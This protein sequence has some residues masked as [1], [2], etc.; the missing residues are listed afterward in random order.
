M[1]KTF[2]SLFFLGTCFFAGAQ[3]LKGFHIG[4]SVMP[5]H[6]WYSN[7]FN[8]TTE[9]RLKSNNNFLNGFQGAINFEYFINNHIGL[10]TGLN[11]SLQKQLFLVAQGDYAN[12]NIN[13]NSKNS[14]ISHRTNYLQIP[15]II[16]YANTINE[17]WIFTVEQGVQFSFLNSFKY[18]YQGADEN[19]NITQTL[20]YTNS[21]TQYTNFNHPEQSYIKNSNNKIYNKNL[22]G[23]VGKIGTKYLIT[24]K[25]FLNSNLVFNYD[26]GNTDDNGDASYLGGYKTH[27]LRA[28]IEFGVSYKLEKK[29]N[30]SK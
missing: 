3:D 7:K 25:F 30:C 13:Y 12:N 14:I 1:R 6:Y 17:K 29:C 2:I 18:I 19:D 28:G 26:F 9:S 22:I 15:L 8:S 4:A 10:K 23:Y 20:I 24:D 21:Y 5:F 27:N 11:Y 16:E